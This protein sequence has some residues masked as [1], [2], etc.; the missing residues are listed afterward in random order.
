[1]S[2]KTRVCADAAS[3]GLLIRS[4]EACGPERNLGP[5]PTDRGEARTLSL[6]VGRQRSVFVARSVCC[7]SA[8]TFASVDEMSTLHVRNIPDDVYEALRKR[9]DEHDSSISSEAVRL[10]R[11]ALRTDRVGVKELLD[12]VE[13]SRPR[14]TRKVSAAQLV[15]R[16][17]DSR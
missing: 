16:D 6:D 2:V 9:A 11:R 15:R 7:N 10:L 8:S 5:V 13:E 3:S 17:R 4:L 14:A 12:E 1:M